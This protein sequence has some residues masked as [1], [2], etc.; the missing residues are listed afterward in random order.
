MSQSRLGDYLEHIEQAA[1]DACSFIEGLSKNDFIEDKGTQQAVIMSLI[2]VGEASTKI[3]DG[4]PEFVAQ[5]N[6]VP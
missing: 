2:I 4:F 1:S 5:H 3:M 6:Q